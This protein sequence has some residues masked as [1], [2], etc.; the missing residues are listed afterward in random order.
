M[1]AMNDQQLTSIVLD[2]LHEVTGVTRSQV[3]PS[4]HLLDYGVDS[5]LAVELLVSLEDRLGIEI[6]DEVVFRLRC[7]DE[8]VRYLGPRLERA[9]EEA[10]AELSVCE[11]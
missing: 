9:N 5:I 2:C 11:G 7:V 10:E 8:I 6:P 1:I 3:V 4:R